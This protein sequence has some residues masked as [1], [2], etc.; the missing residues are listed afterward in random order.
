MG[1]M[2]RT[3]PGA[4]DYAADDRQSPF[5][6]AGFIIMLVAMGVE[7]VVLYVLLKPSPIALVGEVR[8]GEVSPV[9]TGAELVAPT[10]TVPEVVVSVRVREGG[11]EMRTAILSVAVKLGK[12]EGRSEEELDLNYL[13]KAYVPKVEALIPEFRHKLIVMASSTLFDDLRRPETQAK[14]LETM[15]KEMND[16]LES[17]GIEPRINKLFWSTFHFD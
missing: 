5:S 15:K 4:G 2:A 17:Y 12:A 13:E 9:H 16:V 10:V 8:P 7:A 14:M 6:P 3:A 11:T 1:E